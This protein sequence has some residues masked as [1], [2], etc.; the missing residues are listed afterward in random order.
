MATAPPAVQPQAVNAS[1]VNMYG[2]RQGS[3]NYASDT[4]AAMTRDQWNTYANIFVPIENKLI[5]YATDPAVVTNAMA[6]AGEN[7]NDAFDAQGGQ[8]QRR[9]K[10][11]GL[12]LTGEEQA[13]SDRQTGVA[14]ALADVNAQNNARDVTQARQQSILGN[15]VPM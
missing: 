6:T 3:D 9:L 1:G 4:Y 13:S 12:Q 14:R 5:E 2:V 11:Y 7:V 8:T 15:P 10:G